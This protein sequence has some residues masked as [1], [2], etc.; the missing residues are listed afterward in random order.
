MKQGDVIHGYRILG[1]PTNTDA[2]KCLWT[3]AEKDGREFF[4]KEFLDPRRPR[5]NFMGSPE[6]RRAI[7]AQ[8]DEFE[9]RHRSVN[10]R[11]DPKHLHAGNL[12]VPLD[13]FAEGSRYYKVTARVHPTDLRE[14]QELT[15]YG[16][17]VL[18]G[19]LA[20]SLWYLHSLRIVHGDLKPQNVLVHRPDGSDLHTAKLIDFDDAF[21]SGSPPDPMLIGGDPRYGAPEWVGYVRGEPEVGPEQLTIAADMFAFG[22]VAH[23]YLTGGPPGFDARHGSPA[24]AVNAGERLVFDDRLD[25]ELVEVLHALADVRPTARPTIGHVQELLEHEEKLAFRRITTE[26]RRGTGRRSRVRINLDGRAPKAEFG[27]TGE[28][29]K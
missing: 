20:D 9:L 8:C 12:V 22:L 15:P 25:P 14:P 28:K 27:R 2:G 13:F 21:P 19:T 7:E 6:D 3:F 26:S 10:E 29:R 24:E 23:T 18:L 11:I 1:K 16:K 5:P 17:R 4:I